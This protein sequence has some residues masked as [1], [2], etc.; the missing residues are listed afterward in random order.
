MYFSD[1][2]DISDVFEEQEAINREKETSRDGGAPLQ[3]PKVR[4]L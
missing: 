1:D 4:S 3:E 2:S